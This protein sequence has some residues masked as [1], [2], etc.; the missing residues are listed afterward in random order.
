MILFKS[1]YEVQFKYYSRIWIF[2]S[3]SVNNKISKLHKGTLKIVYDAHKSKF[4]KLSLT[5]HH[6][7]IKTLAVEIFKFCNRCFIII[8][9]ITLVVYDLNPTFKFQE[10]ALASMFWTCNLN[11]QYCH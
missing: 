8:I 10:L 5:M 9:K 2:C 11:M 1:F 4:D 7:N 6:Q 3:R